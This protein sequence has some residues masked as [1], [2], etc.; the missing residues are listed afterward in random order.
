MDKLNIDI[1]LNKELPQYASLVKV[2]VIG[3]IV[4]RC[5]N[6][7]IYN[8]ILRNPAIASK[9]GLDT[10][11]LKVDDL[12]KALD[13]V[14]SRLDTIEKKWFS[15]HSKGKEDNIFLYDITST[16]FEGTQ[17][18]LTHFGYNRD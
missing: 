7:D 5:S 2:M 9:L 18:E 1:V 15:H 11:G 16:Y 12:Y 14:Q 6:H 8:W 4:T 3:E 13:F 10:P 17:N